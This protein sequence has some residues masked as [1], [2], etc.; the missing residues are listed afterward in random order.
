MTSPELERLDRSRLVA[1]RILSAFVFGAYRIVRGD[2]LVVGRG[3][4]CNHR[5]IIKGP[6]RVVVGA[7]ANLFAFGTGRRTRLVVRKPGAVIRI[8]ANARVNGTEL[9]ADTSI[10]IGPDCILGQA[11]IADTDAH[12]L[13]AD[14][15]T[16]PD[17]P[18]RSEAVVIEENVWLGRAA[19]ILPGV[20]VGAGSVV[21]Y[22]A[23]VTSDMPPGVLIA[24]N[25]ARVIRKLDD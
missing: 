8:G 24:G 10:D 13:R 18:V 12:S 20:R 25:P 21:A 14:R 9:H 19:S 5:L 16:N 4:I 1:L 23:I 22:G 6:G 11:F 7:G 3:A 2:R 17:A 15:R